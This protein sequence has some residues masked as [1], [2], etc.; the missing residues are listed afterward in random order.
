M[1]IRLLEK[2]DIPV[3]VAAFITIGWDKP[4]PLYERYLR[5]Q[6]SGERTVFVA[7]CDG[8]FAG[9]NTIHWQSDY[10]PFRE[11]QIP[12]IQDFNVLPQFRRQGIGS[13]LMDICEETVA[14]RFR[15]IGIGVG[16]HADYGAAQRMY[17]RRGY[18]LDGRGVM[19]NE[20][21]VPPHQPAPVDDS[22]NLFFTKRLQD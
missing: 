20:Q 18:I 11:A 6:E 2:D 12:E 14:Q 22:L 13:R 9:Y 10:P 21:P 17:T 4:T 15:V 1:E 19:Y 3:I 8:I 5:E 16:L 7:L